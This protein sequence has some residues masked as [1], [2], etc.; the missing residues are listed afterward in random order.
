MHLKQ[1]KL[2]GFKSF[3]DPTVVHFPSQL[4]AVV[5]PNGCGKSNII[6]AVRWVMGESSA[7]NLRGES[8]TDVIF[9]GSAHR[10]P[11]G[12]ASVELVFDNSLGRLAGPF[13]S[14]A[15]IAVKR[16][17]TR[18]GDSSY[19]LNGSR[20]RRKD[21][22]DIFLGTG[23][24]ARGYSIIGQ[25]TISQLIEAKPEDL[26][27]FLEEAA[28]V[29]K[30][31]ERRRETLQRIA[32]TRDN[33]TRVADIRDE[34]D[35]QL[36]RLER[37]AK[38]AE[39]YLVLKEDERIC[40]AQ[41]FAL[42]WHDFLT[43]QQKKQEELQHLALTYTEGQTEL[44]RA[45]T[46]K[47]RLQE[48][49]YDL[50]EKNQQVQAL[51]YQV[52]T[53]I[54]RL[55][56]AMQQQA[57]EQKRLQEEQSQ[58]RHD[59]Q[60]AQEQL[61][62]DQENFSA[63]QE[64]LQDFQMKLEEIRHDFQVQEQQ[65]V[66]AQELQNQL[67]LQWQETNALTSNTQKELHV[68]QLQNTHLQEKQRQ[69]QVRLEKLL[70]EQ[71]AS[72]LNDLQQQQLQ[73][74]QKAASLLENHRFDEQQFALSQQ[75]CSELREKINTNEQQLHFMQDEFH[76]LN[77]ELAALTAAQRAARQGLQVNSELAKKWADKPRLMEILQVE[78]EWQNA[79]ERVLQD[80]LQAYVLESFDEVWVQPAQCTEQG[81]V[82]VTLN[83][84]TSEVAKLPRLRDK[85]RSAYPITPIALEQ[86][87]TAESLEQG[88]TWISQL[89]AHQSIITRE[90]FWFGR[91]WVKY[92]P[93]MVADELGVLARQEK[94]NELTLAVA[95]LQQE[96]TVIR[97]LRDEH[98]RQLQKSQKDYELHQLN[99]K[100]SNEALI[101]N[102]AAL[103]NNLQDIE[104]T[105]KLLLNLEQE[106]RE[107]Q[108]ILEDT[109]GESLLLEER[110]NNLNSQAHELENSQRQQHQ[111]H[112]GCIQK[113]IIL[114]QNLEQTRSLLHQTEL[115]M[116]REHNKVQQLQER[117]TRES[118]RIE[119]LQERL[120]QLALS[121]VESANPNE[122][123]KSQLH[124]LLEK[125]QDIEAQLQTCREQVIQK[126][127]ALEEIEKQI[128][129][130]DLQLKKIQE[131]ISQARIEE[132]S[133][134]VRASS[135]QES[136]TEM[137]F[138]AGQVFQTIPPEVTLSLRETELTEILERI[139]RLGAIN[140]AAI[141]EFTSEQQRKIYLDEQHQDLTEALAT[142]ELAI[143]KMDQETRLRLEATF[144]EVNT[145]FKALF[146]RLFGGG[147]A[148]LELTCENMLEA[149]IVV[150]A[151]PPGKRNSTI[152]LLSG[153]EKAMT[154]VAL[155]FAIFQ[156]NPS[157]FCML[158]EVDAP[159]DDVN[160][161]RFCA[162]V[163]EMSE[164]VQFL[165]ITHNK[166]TM[167]LADHLMG[168]TMRE[169][170][171][172]RLV[173]VDVAQAL[174]LE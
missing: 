127:M 137:E 173:A 87:F 105:E 29:S 72:S 43:Q 65:W 19:Y 170:G 53:D 134:T 41:I 167:E 74:T 61:H 47:I 80:Y 129:Q 46:E 94:I 133:L 121:S 155:V 17:V 27:V 77:S 35:K 138:D 51:F 144:D 86:I 153:G 22:T 110:I 95:K 104:R 107:L 52:G 49:L 140:L 99:V 122:D 123:L 168:V 62:Q 158:D 11:V 117:I 33:L 14:Y 114:R 32:H 66:H 174:S 76:Q 154:A 23:A 102:N 164:F 97:D 151:Q 7:R 28:G 135:V 116:E 106:F 44:T 91:G 37:Q 112:Q 81:M 149:G 150:M 59:L 5:G 166:V 142:L 42:K 126:R 169:P 25:G 101:T 30:Y 63:S 79:C 143:D 103:Q 108:M 31:K 26:R 40:R 68:A 165:F 159:L 152:H 56:E 16:I 67:Q 124:E 1:L 12:Q 3:V 55:E 4:V 160:V 93:P 147:R 38:A 115:S 70:Q 172:S 88:L 145:S 128:N 118:E 34:L 89:D 20:C 84:V 13:A 58:L 9:N 54:A 57:R 130:Q 96:I 6:D 120:E 156:L 2:A 98:H 161:G 69:T 39:R 148:Q 83:E 71:E 146:P 139:K 141:E 171:V 163:R 18:D 50:D 109:R 21:I 100:A 113:N 8:M 60:C 45:Q 48:M 75:L 162:M 136:L 73:L 157:P 15:E 92:T 119:L 90:G 125:H 132:E 24:G 85:V 36:Q 64:D 82:V 111:D 10:K 131:H 78:P